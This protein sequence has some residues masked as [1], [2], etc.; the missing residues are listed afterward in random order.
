MRKPIE[1]MRFRSIIILSVMLLSIGFSVAAQSHS[2]TPPKQGEKGRESD[3]KPMEI[4]EQF[5]SKI[6]KQLLTADYSIE[7]LTG[8]QRQQVVS[9]KLQMLGNCFRM[10]I[11]STEAAFDG[12]T[13]YMYQ[14]ETNELTLSIPTEEEL[15]DVNPLIFARALLRASTIRFAANAKA[16]AT[17]VKTKS[18]PTASAAAEV[19]TLDVLPVNKGAG[20]QRIVIKMR[21]TDLAP[22]EIQIREQ[23]EQT[24]IRF[25]QPSFSHTNPSTSSL[26]Q[27]DYPSAWLNDL[28]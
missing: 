1:K 10:T 24:I 18:N 9:G 7:L 6:E 21:K 20:I 8:T 25:S 22:L 13:L 5:I 14:K 2:N 19:V 4:A 23:Q 16:T 28:R 26:F 11:L 15:L 12:K 17:N 27:L 3:S